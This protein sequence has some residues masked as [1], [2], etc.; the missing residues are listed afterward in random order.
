MTANGVVSEMLTVTGTTVPEAGLMTGVATVWAF[1]LFAA[2][3]H[4]N[5]IIVAATRQSAANFAF[6]PTAV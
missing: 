5:A 6:L 4:A 1:V 2:K 3:S